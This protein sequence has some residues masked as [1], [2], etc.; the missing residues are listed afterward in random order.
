MRQGFG[1]LVALLL[2]LPAAAGVRPLGSKDVGATQSAALFVG[3]RD[4][5][6]S[7]RLTQVRYAVDDAVDLAYEL[8]IGQSR[9]L[10]PPERVVLALSPG[11]PRKQDSRRRLRELLAAG[12]RRRP[13]EQAEILRLIGQQA[14]LVG[15]DGILIVHF[16][17]H[18]VAEGGAQQLLARGSDL[19]RPETMIAVS[20]INQ[21]VSAS[22][23]ARS[24]ILIDACRENLRRDRR[25][26]VPDARSK[27][28]FVRV[29]TGVEGQVIITGAAR[30]GY[31]YDDE[32][33]HNGVFTATIIDGL[34]CAARKDA[35][36]FVTVDGLYDYVAR[37]VLRW[38][39][40]NKNRRARSATQ[41]SC[42]GQTKRMPLSI[43]GLGRTASA[44][45]E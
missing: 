25:A 9:P 6:D 30:G 5:A 2:S 7:G 4:F 34:R 41:L 8:A 27:A 26:G 36:G 31:A 38:V 10:V 32:V 18:G 19:D 11:E 35:H 28:A 16:A 15:V 17:T 20:T 44:A 12:A 42:D 40:K 3:I 33:R 39:Q 29:T 1:I 13:A 43:C 22:D 14:R 23:V 45:S 21:I 37:E 24:L